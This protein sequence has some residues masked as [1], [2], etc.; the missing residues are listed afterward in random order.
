MVINHLLNGMILQVSDTN[1]HN[2]TNLEDHPL[3]G[4]VV[5]QKWLFPKIMEILSSDD[6]SQT[7]TQPNPTPSQ[8][9]G[10]LCVF[11]G[12]RLTKKNPPE[13]CRYGSYHTHKS[14]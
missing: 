13:V 11:V 3:T 8:T 14:L 1:P 9:K 4:K 6:V 12:E 10:V 2:P 5:E 7:Q